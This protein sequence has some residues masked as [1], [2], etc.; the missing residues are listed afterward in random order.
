MTI[1]NSKRLIT[2]NIN[3]FFFFSFFRFVHSC[4]LLLIF[5]DLQNSF[6]KIAGHIIIEKVINFNLFTII[7]TNHA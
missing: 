2:A 6:F 4:L 7:K 1:M 3:K 5:P